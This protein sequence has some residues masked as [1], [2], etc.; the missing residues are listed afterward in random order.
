MALLAPPARI[1]MEPMTST[2]A[3]LSQTEH[4]DRPASERSK[5][6]LCFG[7][8]WGFAFDT[9]CQ[10]KVRFGLTAL[11]M[12][13]GTAS[14]ILVVTIGMTGKEYVLRQIQAVGANMIYAYQEA[15]S[16]PAGRSSGDYLTI[17]DL[18][19]VQ[20][21]V[22]G[23]VHAAAMV[24]RYDR[25]PVAGGKERNILVLGVSPEYQLVRNLQVPAGRFF[26]AEDNMARNKVAVIT[27]E[28]ARTSF[29]S[30]DAA[31]GRELKIGGL[32]FTIIGTFRESV[33]T[34]GQSEIADDTILIPLRVIR[35]FTN[36]DAV[37]QLFFSVSDPA[38][39]T[40]ASEQIRTVLRS[41]HRPG[42]AFRVDNLTQ[43]ISVAAKVA[44]AL[45]IVLLLVSAVTLVVSGVGIMNIMLATVTARIREIGIR[46]AIGATNREIKFQFLAEAVF[47]SLIGGLLGIMIGLALPLSVR[48]LTSFRIPISALS[49]VVA[50]GVSTLVGVIFGTAPAARAANLDPVES[51]RYE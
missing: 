12:V 33:E 18:N 38:E 11:G 10:N 32:P 36:T 34:F 31:V 40:R 2:P 37:K 42:T 7:E 13:I 30:D 39:V 22:P 21:E 51:L 35:Y 3:S 24:D 45:T 23:I 15:P 28:L 4:S 1:T 27:S 16:S 14:L 44:D 6:K 50:L 5:P 49:V 48:F 9:F 8:I 46:K 43:I 17:D 25:I 29:G 19:A 47:I 41:R 20:Q 26:S